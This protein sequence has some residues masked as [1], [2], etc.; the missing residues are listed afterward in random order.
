LDL[1]TESTIKIMQEHREKTRKVVEQ[2]IEAE[3]SFLYTTDTDY[4]TKRGAF[5]QVTFP[6]CISSHLPFIER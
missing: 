3:S 6:I 2:V 5:F 4:L 1:I